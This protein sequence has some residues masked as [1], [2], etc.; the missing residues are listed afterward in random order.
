MKVIAII[1]LVLL[2]NCKISKGINQE[3][4]ETSKYCTVNIH[5]AD[6][7]YE[8]SEPFTVIKEL[9][10]PLN[11][12][13]TDFKGNATLKIIRPIN[14]SIGLVIGLMGSI[15]GDTIYLG[16]KKCI[17]VY[18]YDYYSPQWYRD[19]S[20]KNPLKIIKYNPDLNYDNK[21]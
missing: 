5:I 8:N 11:G 12:A 6:S 17:D 20:K 19:Y 21:K 15:G 13:M 9:N 14:D 2:M 16:T 3:E 4:C 7:L 1:T 10:N 18:N